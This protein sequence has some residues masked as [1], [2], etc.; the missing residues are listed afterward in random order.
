MKA[1]T[2]RR[3]A[4]GG[5]EEGVLVREIERVLEGDVEGRQLLRAEA[6][7]EIRQGALW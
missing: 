1:K 2:P 7:H 5:F 3:P 4:P 6:A